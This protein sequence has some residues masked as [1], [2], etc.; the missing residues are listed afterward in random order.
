VID[1]I[2][3]IP[4]QSMEAEQSVLGSV[5]IDNECLKVVS[6]LIDGSDF[7]REP[8]RK[9]YMAMLH[10]RKNGIP[11][12]L[13]TISGTL[14]SSGSLEEI[15]GGAYL[16]TLVDFV[17]TSA[18]VA[19]YCKTVKEMAVRRQMIGYAQNLQE[20]AYGLTDVGDIIPSAKEG[21]SLMSASLDT[22]GG[23]NLKDLATRQDRMESYRNQVKDLSRSRFT[24]G[25]KLIDKNIRG[26]APGEVLTI[27]AEPGGFKTAFVLNIL[28]R[29]ITRTKENNLFFSMDMTKER[30]FEREVQMYNGCSGWEVEKFYQGTGGLY[31]DPEKMERTGADTI[32]CDKTKLSAEQMIRYYELAER[33][34]GKINCIGIDYIQHMAGAG[35]IFDRVEMNAY[36]VSDMAKELKVPIICLSQINVVGRKEKNG[37]NFC[38]AK[39]GGAIEEKARIGLGFYHDKNGSLVCECLKNNNG[40]AG[41]KLEADIDKKA[42]L[43]RDFIEYNDVKKPTSEDFC[44]Y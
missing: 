41:W 13:V 11:I 14:K 29:A 19:F 9:I 22:F 12:D 33:K 7:F 39:G 10:H 15:G 27:V 36:A 30:L 3:K 18:N 28:D 24:T 17:P 2:R 26:I 4:P 8:H 16:Y 38:D 40:R 37:I 23:V 43:F 25:F 35:K 1:S 42:F 21:L 44:P 34:F 20:M 31:V 32:I 5:F 6:N